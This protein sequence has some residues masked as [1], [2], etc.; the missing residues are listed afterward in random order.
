MLFWMY[1]YVT[2]KSLR[3]QHHLIKDVT[4]TGKLNKTVKANSKWI[5]MYLANCAISVHFFCLKII[6]PKIYLN[7]CR[8][9][10]SLSRNYSTSYI[11]KQAWSAGG[12]RPDFVE[13]SQRWYCECDW[14]LPDG[15]W[16][17]S[18]YQRQP[19][20]QHDHE[21]VPWH[22]VTGQRKG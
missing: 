14:F 1:A 9:V 2:E 22:Q 10:A 20:L 16:W 3:V 17:V 6:I 7:V 19:F 13:C 12:D 8:Y 11:Y 5:W 4:L 18:P 15:L 21:S